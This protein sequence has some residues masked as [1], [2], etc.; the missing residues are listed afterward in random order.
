MATIYL[1]FVAAADIKHYVGLPSIQAI[2]KIYQSRMLEL[3]RQM[4]LYIPDFTL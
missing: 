1:A 3:K 2:Y 4:N